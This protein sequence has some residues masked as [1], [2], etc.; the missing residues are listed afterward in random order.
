MYLNITLKT[1]TATPK[2]GRLAPLSA[3]T[4]DDVHVEAGYGAVEVAADHL[5]AVASHHALTWGEV[6][7]SEDGGSDNQWDVRSVDV[8]GLEVAAALVTDEDLVTGEV[9]V[10]V[11]GEAV[12]EAA[13]GC[14]TDREAGSNLA[15][16]VEA[17]AGLVED[18]SLEYGCH[19]G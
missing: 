12:G 19:I 2:G 4:S 6:L 10:L 13:D 16:A 18:R 17:V 1:R 3:R 14:C 7:G 11:D 5:L 9:G 15:L 8:A